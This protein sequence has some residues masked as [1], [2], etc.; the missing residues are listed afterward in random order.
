[1][2]TS[3]ITRDE[4]AARAALLTVDSYAV[5]LDLTTDK[6]GS[7]EHYWSTTTVTFS[8]TTP[9]ATTWIDLIA[10]P[11]AVSEVILNGESLDAASLYDGFR[12]TLPNVAAQNTLT[13]KATNDYNTTGVGLHRLV[14]PADGEVYLYTQFEEADA[15]RMFACFD[16]PDLKATYA[17]NI[18]APAHW[19]VISNAPAPAPVAAR[20]GFATWNFP[21]TKKMSTYITALIGGP[22]AK[23]EDSYTG[24]FGTIPLGIFC[25]KSMLQYL[26]ADDMFRDT[27]DGFAFFEKTFNTPYPFEKYD[28]VVVPQFNAGAMEN[29]GCVTFNEDLTIYRGA[30][31]KTMYIWRCLVILHE[32]AHMWFGNLVTMEWWDDLWLNESFAEFSCYYA[33]SEGDKFS[34]ESWVEFNA[35]RK[36]WGYTADQLPST[37][38]IQGDVPDLDSV[39]ANFDGIS[40]AKGASVLRQLAQF[41]GQDAFN[42]GVANYLHKHAWGNATL[43]DLLTELEASSGRDLKAWT[44]DWLQTPGVNTVRPE[45]VIAADGTYESVTVVQEPAK[46]PAGLPAVLRDHVM[47]IGRYSKD[48][49]GNLVRTGFDVVNIGGDRTLIEALK[50]QPAADLLL[51]NDGDYTFTKIRLDEASA[52]TATTSLGRI[53]DPLARALLWSAC[54]DMTR[55]AQLSMGDYLTLVESALPYETNESAIEAALR[56][57]ATGIATYSAPENRNGYRDRFV[58][59]LRASID[60]APAGSSTQ[61]QVVKAYASA[62]RT[63]EQAQYVRDLFDGTVTLEGRPVDTELGWHFLAALAALDMVSDAEIDAYLE[64]DP[65]SN[66]QEAALTARTRKP[67]AA[68][69]AAAWDAIYNDEKVTNSA[70]RAYLTGFW[71]IDQLDILRPYV[72]KYFAEIEGVFV[73]R[74]ESVAMV[75]SVG[76]FPSIFVEQSVLEKVTAFGKKDLHTALKRYTAENRDR[77]ERAMRCQAKDADKVLANA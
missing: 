56:N 28:Q 65:T 11:G 62:V 40:Y 30:V 63:K 60:K 39:R 42:T 54:W 66:G 38:P 2:A 12:V 33:M 75:T 22:Y 45:I 17:F 77:L 46:D 72:D 68:A 55:D 1:M 36:T 21:A 52:K 34:E 20:D 25:R 32:M 18:T 47:G 10:Q 31:P 23:V 24:Q 61:L 41:V 74:A 15:R 70:V 4:A 43:A 69:K 67:N 5:D 51:L 64:K 29:A 13:I 19:L 49:S 6:P 26:E 53:T 71:H 3:N 27:K 50:G 14:D 35:L 59:L 73:K 9:G 44:K 76:T 48:A 16:Q 7:D 37:H 58:A 57:L 8:A